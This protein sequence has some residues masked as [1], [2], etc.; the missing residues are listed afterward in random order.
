LKFVVEWIN[1]P[2]MSKGFHNRQ[3]ENFW[4]IF[5]RVQGRVPWF[6]WMY[7]NN[8]F[9]PVNSFLFHEGAFF[10]QLCPEKECSSLLMYVLWWMGFKINIVVIYY[11]SNGTFRSNCNLYIH[12]MGILASNSF[13]RKWIGNFVGVW[14]V[15]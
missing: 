11:F 4:T 14:R 2:I 12:Q 6:W 13:T 15:P 5:W 3:Y 7:S 1:Y 8:C 9:T 10:S